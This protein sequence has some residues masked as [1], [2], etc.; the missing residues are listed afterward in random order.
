MFRRLVSA[1][2]MVG[3]ILFGGTVKAQRP[4]PA[5][6]VPKR[7]ALERL[8]LER[9]WFA[10]VPLVETERLLAISI[11]ADLLF[12]QTSYAMVHAFEAET[13]RLLWSAQIGER[14][15]FARGV[16]ANSFSVFVTNANIFHALNKKTGR[17][18]WRTNV[19]TIPTSSPACDENLAM[20]G[21][22]SG[23]LTAFNLKKK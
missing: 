23:M 3:T 6:L 19:N 4:F 18:I 8:G 5:N 9:Q 12:A 13:G 20:V 2:V 11:G 21:L 16:A 10:V 22:T 15:G 17:P 1:L 14:T 7:S